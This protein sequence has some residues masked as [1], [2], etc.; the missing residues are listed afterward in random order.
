VG[1]F[2]R[3]DVRLRAGLQSNTA[4]TGR[5]NSS[6]SVPKNGTSS[7]TS[8]RTKPNNV[9]EQIVIENEYRNIRLQAKYA[10][11]INYQSTK[12]HQLYRLTVLR[13]NLSIEQNQRKLLD[14][15]ANR[16]E[17]PFVRTRAEISYVAHQMGMRP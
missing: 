16:L 6:E 9:K 14:T 2:R 17:A 10:A 4:R 7:E 12:C 3:R 5:R 8:P 15:R 11:K 1:C 13:K